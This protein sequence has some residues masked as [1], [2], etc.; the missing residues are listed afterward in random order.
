MVKCKCVAG[1]VGSDLALSP[2]LA[3]SQL[4]VLGYEH[5]FMPMSL[6]VEQGWPP[7]PHRAALMTEAAQARAQHSMQHPGKALPSS[8]QGSGEQELGHP[9]GAP[10]PRQDWGHPQTVP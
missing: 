2:S 5:L 7:P 6:S 4:C 8:L 3:T 9:Q 1:P 10:P